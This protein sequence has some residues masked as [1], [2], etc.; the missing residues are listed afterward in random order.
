[1]RVAVDFDDER[2]DLDV[3]DGRVLAAWHGPTGRAA[4]DVPGLVAGAL[5][6]PLDYPP[7]RQAVVPGDRVV[8]A[9]GD[10]VPESAALLG[11][12]WRVLEGSGVEPSGLTVLT[13]AAAPPG[14][15]AAVPTGVEFR[16]HDPADRANLSYLATTAG[17]RR[18][19]LNRA[20][21]DADFV[22]PVGRLAYDPVLGY[23]G[24]WGV[25]FPGSSDAEAIRAARAGA[26]DNPADRRHP[27]A[28]LAESA[29]VS[30]LLGSQFQVG[31]VGGV[32]GVVGAL[33]G[34]GS[35]VLERGAREVDTAWTVSPPGR[36]DLVVAGV[37]R[38][39]VPSGVDEVARG[40]ANAARLVE[41]GGK[42]VVL[43]RAGGPIGPALG[44][45]RGVSD[46]RAAVATLRGHESDPD[47]PAARQIARALA[48][49]DVYLLSALGREDVEDL[50]MI[51]LDRA[52]EARRLAAVC[53]SCLVLSQADL[54]R[55]A[56]AGDTP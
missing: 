11:A 12:V 37:G 8:I 41:R 4:A 24:P 51:A 5:E 27:R 52:E 10:D 14:L 48:W 49:A 42:I 21:T 17:G 13:G 16:R 38:P 30:W 39:G 9:L 56:V 33:A 2:I 3:P 50:G 29:E 44:R 20:L 55:A 22:L 1:M 34:L 19:Y 36:A 47:Y 18:V 23:G 53:G 46:P 7:L 35:A 25:I 45:L 31:L 26:D 28:A 32:T 43:S 40:L 6:R 54:A 15:A